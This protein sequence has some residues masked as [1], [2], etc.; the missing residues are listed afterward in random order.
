MNRR[1]LFALLG[2]SARPTAH[3]CVLTVQDT[4]IAMCAQPV[5]AVPLQ[6]ALF[7]G[8]ILC[9]QLA[10]ATAFVVKFR[11]RQPPLC[12]FWTEAHALRVGTGQPRFTCA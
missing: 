12:G 6:L 7:L 10:F 2:A 1:I 11:L 3:Q 5:V 8:I 4:P 9:I